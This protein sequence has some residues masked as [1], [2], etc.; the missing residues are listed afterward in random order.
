MVTDWSL[1]PRRAEAPTLTVSRPI[2]MRTRRLPMPPEALGRELVAAAFAAG[3]TWLTAGFP[4]LVAVAALVSGWVALAMLLQH[5]RPAMVAGPAR[6]LGGPL[7]VVAL[8]A[9]GQWVATTLEV[10]LPARV[11]PT[12]LLGFTLTAAAASLFISLVMLTVAA[13][14]PLRTLV[15]GDPD[16]SAS[17]TDALATLDADSRGRL[18]GVGVC[19]PAEVAEVVDTVGAQVVLVVPG[20]TVTDREVQRVGWQLEELSVPLLVASGIG[21]VAAGRAT[22]ARI[23]TLGVVEVGGGR[24][25]GPGAAAKVAWERTAAAGALLILA[26]VLLGLALWVRLDSPGP[27]LFRQVRVG[28]DGR[29]F[30]M[31]KL[32]TMRCDA[33]RVRP[34]LVSEGN[35]VLFKVHRDPRVTRAGRILRRYSLDELPQLVNVVR[36]EMSLVGP[37]PALPDEVASYDTDPRRRL[38]VKPGLTGLWQVSGRS[39]LD[40]TESVRLDLDYVDNWSLPRDLGIVARTVGAVLSHRGAY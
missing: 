10:G 12:M 6:R 39:D 16:G 34:S 35:E 2:P 20:P 40:W 26:P 11:S 30:T 27:A 33:E 21:H 24:P 28:R 22:A 25:R 14:A 5:R 13:P 23:G 9:V 36:G 8:V 37:R 19:R 38:R 17:P 15:V 32:R 18:V 7:R 29:T 3:T 4:G 1:L 31:L